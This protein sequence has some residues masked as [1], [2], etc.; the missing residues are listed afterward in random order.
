MAP[1]L[2]PLSSVNFTDTLLAGE[3]ALRDTA[4]FAPSH[5][6]LRAMLNLVRLPASIW[7]DNSL[8]TSHAGF[9]GEHGT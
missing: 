4:L 1:S 2:V 3:N 6:K 9:I 5:M 7:A 8:S